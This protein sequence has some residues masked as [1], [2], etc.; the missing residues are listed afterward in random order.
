M[1]PTRRDLARLLPAAIVAPALAAEEP[2]LP[3]AV[4]SFDELPAKTNAQNG[5]VTRQVLDGLTHTGYK[6]EVH[7]TELS[8]GEAPHP[9]HRHVHEEM[10][11]M[12]RGS[13]EVTIAGKATRLGPGS[14]AYVAS[15]MEHGWRNVGADRALYFVL[16]LGPDS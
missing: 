7:L 16:A 15:N 13:L 9:P 10:V 4:F 1:P 6:V 11:L 8:P 3:S 14:S 2:N 12:L 5:N